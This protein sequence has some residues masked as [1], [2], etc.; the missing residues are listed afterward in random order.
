MFG[1]TII[2][3]RLTRHHGVSSVDHRRLHPGHLLDGRVEW[4]MVAAVTQLLL[5][6]G[7][8][9]AS[10]IQLGLKPVALPLMSLNL[11]IIFYFCSVY[12]IIYILISNLPLR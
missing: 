1:N 10:I 5:Q 4:G 8:G 6:A 9:R 7:D 3:W 12:N 2:L 11:K